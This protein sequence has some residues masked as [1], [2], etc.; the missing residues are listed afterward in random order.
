MRFPDTVLVLMHRTTP[1]VLINIP[2]ELPKV[3]GLIAETKPALQSDS[4]YLRLIELVDR[5]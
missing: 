4:R 2:H 3:L 1:Q 5:S